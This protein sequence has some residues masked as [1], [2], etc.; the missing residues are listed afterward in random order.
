MII[1]DAAGDLWFT[2]DTTRYRL[3]F[4]RYYLSEQIERIKVYGKKTEILLQSDRPAIR[5]NKKRSAIKW[6]IISEIKPEIF[7]NAVLINTIFINLENELDKID[8]P[9]APTTHRKNL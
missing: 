6:K 4:E 2:A 5:N 3:K 1:Q 7:K 8:Y 9:K